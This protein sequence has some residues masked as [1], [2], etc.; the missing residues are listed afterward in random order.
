M[1]GYRRDLETDEGIDAA[2][3]R[4]QLVHERGAAH[5]FTAEERAKGRTTQRASG[6]FGRGRFRPV[7][8]EQD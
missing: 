8:P 1:K 2:R 7:M 5:R 3:R 6:R 4:A